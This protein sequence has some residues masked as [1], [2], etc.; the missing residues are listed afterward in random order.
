MR[1][2]S[3]TTWLDGRLI[4]NLNLYWNDISDYQASAA[5][6]TGPTTRIYLTNAA[7]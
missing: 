1:R 4:A 3:R 7:R 6:T 5:V 2:A